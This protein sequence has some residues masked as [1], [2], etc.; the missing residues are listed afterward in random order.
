MCNNEI[1]LI[2]VNMLQQCVERLVNHDDSYESIVND[3]Y[4]ACKLMRD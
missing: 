1:M 4:L 2:S 3:I